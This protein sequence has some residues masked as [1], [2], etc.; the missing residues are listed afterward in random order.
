MARADKY[1]LREL[2][3][4]FGT[5]EACLT[6]LFDSLHS[7]TCSC[8][9]TYRF[10]SPRKYQCSKC[11][12]QISPT[13][14]TIFENSQTPLTLWFHALYL[15]SNAKSGLSA[16][17]LERDLNIT[18][19]TSWRI[20]SLI[21]S[22][23]KPTGLLQGTVEVDEAYLGGVRL[24]KDRALKPK[25]VGLVERGGGVRAMVVPWTSAKELLWAITNNVTP[26]ATVYTDGNPSYKR[27]PKSGY[28][29]DRVNHSAHEYVRGKVHVNSVEAFWGHVKRSLKG[30]HKTVSQQHLQTYLDAYAWH[31]SRHND[32]ARFGE[33]L[34][35]VLSS[36]KVRGR[37]SAS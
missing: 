32:R 7:R 5:D 35:A 6:F 23:L 1:G 12:F 30:V 31:Y 2:R 11:R 4:D 13:A 36:A 19:K 37:K 14:G 34:G 18:Y 26:G 3:A 10:K 25:A 16:S 21:R 8:G 9:G 15:F 20:L 28:G 24:K 27:V 33:L 22:S 17:Q 29:W